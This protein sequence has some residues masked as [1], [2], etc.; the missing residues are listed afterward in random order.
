MN[1][2]L[3]LFAVLAISSVGL[4]LIAEDAEATAAG[5]RGRIAFDSDLAVDGPDSDIYVRDFGG[6]TPIPLTTNTIV[7][8]TDPNWSPDGSTIAYVSKPTLTGKSSIWVVPSAGGT[9]TRITPDGGQRH[10]PR[11]GRRMDP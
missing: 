7:E 1:R 10:H 9:A 8:D 4:V 2:L 3:I 6:G 11:P 5:A